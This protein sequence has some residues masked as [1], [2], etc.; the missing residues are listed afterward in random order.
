[1]K[2]TMIAALAVAA[3]LPAMASARV[4]VG[5]RP[6]VGFGYGYGYG[7]YW[8]PYYGGPY[9][10][11]SV[12][13]STGAV[14]FDTHDKAASVFVNGAF[15]GAVGDV[16]TLNLK[17]G[18]Y[19]IQVS[20]PGRASFDE[21]VFVGLGKTVKIRPELAPIASPMSAQPTGA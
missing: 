13:P 17:P 4:I 14:K 2:K 18:T 19:E 16:K 11:Y 15:V 1:M 6:M 7:P 5:I 20:E 8:G 12:R 3:F 9:G 10:A 21:K